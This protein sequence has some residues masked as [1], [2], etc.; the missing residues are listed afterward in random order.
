MNIR[1]A[2]FLI[3][4]VVTVMIAACSG[5]GDDVAGIGGSGYIATGSVSGFG[6]VYVNGIKFET[7]SAIFEVEDETSSQ[8]SLRLGMVVNVSGSINADG[9]SG[10]A[11]GIR[12]GDQLEGPVVA[13]DGKT[14]IFVNA[15]ATT[16]LFSVL[17]TN[18]LVDEVETVFE[19]SNFSF[20][21]LGLNNVVEVS[22]YYD[23][24]DVLRATY[25]ERKS[26]TFDA[27]TIVEIVGEISNLNSSLFNIR[28][29][30]VN[31]SSANLSGLPNGLENGRYV[32][33][34]GTYNV[35]T[36][37]IAAIEVEYEAIEYNDDQNVSLEGYITRYVSKSDFDINGIKV[38]A[39]VAQFEP[40]TLQLSLGLKVE[41]EGVFRDG[42]FV[43]DEIEA[44]EGNAA[45][46]AQ[47]DSINLSAG[48]FKVRPVTG[49]PTIS[50]ATDSGTTL[51]DDVLEVEPF[52][53][54][55]LQIGDFVEVTAL[56]INASS[57]LAIKVK[58]ANFEKVLV[59]GTATSASGDNTSGTITVLGVQFTTDGSTDFEN[60]NDINLT[61]GEID[62]LLIS[63]NTTPTLIKIKADD[64]GGLATEVD[65]ED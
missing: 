17:G 42:V 58:R 57:V 14:N 36:N 18:V 13:S 38:N 62:S 19:G 51:E 49:E 9:V 40:A 21:S 64:Q 44:E 41:A 20:D 55:D 34:K 59:Q 43:A 65:V 53:L 52:K 15:D 31:A 7:D 6:S 1:P 56:E 10:V 63:I 3:T 37:V 61:T 5:G 47:V 35:D 8:Q 23:Q 46:H 60:D 54:S 30:T 39:A 16:K 50:V 11:T 24:N 48:T 45:I 22:G 28:N 27:T 25:I 2:K 33:V 4:V 26:T 12:Y 29:V 32:E